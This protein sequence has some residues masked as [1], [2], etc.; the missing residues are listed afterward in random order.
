MSKIRILI[1][2]DH[3]VLRAGLKM[4][5]ENQPDMTVVGEAGDGEATLA[6]VRALQPDVLLLDVTMPGKDGLAVL[7][8]MGQ[9]SPKTRTLLLTMHEEDAI[10]RAALA[11]GA[12]GYVLKRTVETLFLE[13]VRAVMRGETFL[14][15][16]LSPLLIRS[17]LN[18]P[19]QENEPQQEAL[20]DGLTA[21]EVEVLRLVARG[22]TNREIAESLVISIK[23]VESHKAH[24]AAKLGLKSRAEILRYA[25][26]KGLLKE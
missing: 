25:R 20:P 22:Y 9:V 1:A 8:A 26:R 5:I 15:P 17:Y 19:P 2:D 21:R 11:A 14:D 10:L 7:R 13:A 24:L 6:L 3:A 12:A 16:A 23:T 4:L 18:Q